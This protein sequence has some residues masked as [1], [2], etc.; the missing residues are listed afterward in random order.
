[1][2]SVLNEDQVMINPVSLTGIPLLIVVVSLGATQGEGYGTE[3]SCW[4]SVENKVIWA[5]VG[6][7]F[8]VILVGALISI[9]TTKVR[10]FGTNS[11]ITNTAIFARTKWF[12]IDPYCISS[13]IS[14]EL[15]E[16]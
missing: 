4:L 3:S 16:L 13:G 1:V 5:F 9:A 10:C 6:P 15:I 8:L 7:A 14:L 11:V 12:S 2:F